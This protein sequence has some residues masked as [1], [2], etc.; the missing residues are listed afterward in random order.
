[1]L[2]PRGPPVHDSAA[3]ATSLRCLAHTL[4]QMHEEWGRLT[5]AV[6]DVADKQQLEQS[7]TASVHWQQAHSADAAVASHESG[8]AALPAPSWQARR[9][10]EAAPARTGGPWQ[11][12]EK[13]TTSMRCSTGRT[14][15]KTDRNAMG[16]SY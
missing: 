8:G 1:M 3:M 15:S 12:A 14:A 10:R 7:V 5:C 6:G 11:K 2:A 13:S 4:V 16:V 9:A